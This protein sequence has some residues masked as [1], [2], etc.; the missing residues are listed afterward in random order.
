LLEEEPA[1]AMRRV[2][3]GCLRAWLVSWAVLIG[4][5]IGFRSPTVENLAALE[6]SSSSYVKERRVEPLPFPARGFWH[7]ADSGSPAWRTVYLDQYERI[8]RCGLLDSMNVTATFVGSNSA[9]MPTF[10]DPRI[11]VGYGGLQTQYEY[12]S[13]VRLDEYCT[14]VS[15]TR[16]TM[17]RFSRTFCCLLLP[18]RLRAPVV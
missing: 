16:L 17:S 1:K 2:A 10:D 11:A 18:V 7:I 13:L 14:K 3:P 4:L 12:P 6:A 8:K 15:C 9:S 5:F